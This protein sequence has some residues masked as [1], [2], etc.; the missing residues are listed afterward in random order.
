MSRILNKNILY[1][2]YIID[3]A[4]QA[5]LFIQLDIKMDKFSEN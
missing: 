3:I 4:V 2:L 5:N 1:R